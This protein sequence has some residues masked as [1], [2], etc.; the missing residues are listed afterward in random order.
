MKLPNSFFGFG[1][2]KAKGSYGS[3]LLHAKDEHGP[4][5]LFGIDRW[6]HVCLAYEKD[7]GTV[8]VFRVGPFAYW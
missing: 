5:E 3:F 7:P 1:N 2:P 8:K 4:M 6:T